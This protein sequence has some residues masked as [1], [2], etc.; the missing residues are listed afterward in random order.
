MVMLSHT[1]RNLYAE[2]YGN[3]TGEW[4]KTKKEEKSKEKKKNDKNNNKKKKLVM[5][6][7]SLLCRFVSVV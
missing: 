2:E 3:E 5:L 7:V 6:I 4:R 1:E